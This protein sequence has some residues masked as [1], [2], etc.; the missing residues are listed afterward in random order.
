MMWGRG[1]VLLRRGH[2]DRRITFARATSNALFL[3]FWAR[4]SRNTAGQSPLLRRDRWLDMKLQL[5]WNRDIIIV[6]TE[7]SGTAL[8]FQRHA[9]HPR[10]N[11]QSLLKRLG[12]QQAR[13][14][15]CVNSD[16]LFMYT[17]TRNAMETSPRP[18]VAYDAVRTGDLKAAGECQ[19]RFLIFLPR[20]VINCVQI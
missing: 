11:R 12:Q 1:G 10:H 2:D 14:S 7:L 5:S 4:V 3:T 6:W 18:V 20:S 15:R 8:K 9:L 19:V 13:I 17:Q 16:L